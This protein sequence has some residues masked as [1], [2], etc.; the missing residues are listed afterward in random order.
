MKSSVAIALIIC[1]TVLIALPYIHNT[2]AMQQV[3]NTMVALN[4]TVNLT[5]D[6]PKHASTVCMLGGTIMIVVGAI[7]GSRT[8]KPD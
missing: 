8:D 1:G 5:A 6:I 3:A 2:V 4:K 7:A